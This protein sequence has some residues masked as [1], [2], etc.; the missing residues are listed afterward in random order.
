MAKG[1]GKYGDEGSRQ[2][3][4]SWDDEQTKFMVNWYIEYRK[5]QHAGFV[6]KKQHHMKCADVLNKE[7]A[8]GGTLDQDD[9]HYGHYKE[10]WTIV[11]TAMNKSGNGFDKIKCKVTISESGKEQLSDRARRLLSKPIKFFHEMQELFSGMNADGS[12][13]MDPETGLDDGSGPSD[14]DSE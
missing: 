6:F 13:A 1:K 10:N 12:L 14:S 3:T 11:E 5:E 2:R 4:M 8:M 7:F 9:C